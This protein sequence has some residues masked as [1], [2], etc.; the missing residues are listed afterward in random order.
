MFPAIA[1]QFG[2]VMLAG[3]VLEG[4]SQGRD[5]PWIWY[6]TAV[7]LAAIIWSGW[8]WPTTVI[9]NLL[10]CF[11]LGSVIW[12]ILDLERRQGY[13]W[14][15]L[16]LLAVALGMTMVR[17][18][19]SVVLLIL[20]IRQG[21][22]ILRLL[23]TRARWLDDAA[24]TFYRRPVLLFIG[25][26]LL[27]IVAGTVIL[28]F[29]LSSRL[30]EGVRLIDAL[31]TATSAV[32]VTGLVVLDTGQDF[33]GFGQT[34]ILLLFQVGGLGVLTVSTFATLLIT[35]HLSMR[36]EYALEQ[37][38]ETDRPAALFRLI[39][40]IVY[41][42]L[43]IE[44]A[45]ALL[46]YLT[47]DGWWSALFHSVSAFCNAGFSLNSDSLCGLQHN[48]AYLMTVTLLIVLGGLGFTV[49]E[50]I[51]ARLD[52]RRFD[53]HARLA[54]IGTLALILIGFSGMVLQ[55][56]NGGLAGLEPV[57]KV[58]NALFQSVTT[59]T[60]GFNSIPY[61][62]LQDS[63]V[64]L[65]LILMFIGACPGSTGGG[66]KVTTLLVLLLAVRAVIRGQPDVESGGRRIPPSIV[67]RA[68]VVVTLAVTMITVS[69]FLL[70]ATQVGPFREMAFEAVSAFA[71][72]GLS[73]GQTARLDDL[74][75]LVVIFLMF[76]GRVGPLSLILMF[77]ADKP[78]R[79]TLPQENILVG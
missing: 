19:G 78:R 54:L 18:G 12:S 31:F 69:L 25:G 26:F 79:W 40:F 6:S 39:R 29:H 35:G 73:L 71:T 55:E 49:I 8:L 3:S 45:G 16:V 21:W 72:V 5:T 37:M 76:A 51:R 17:K 65:M 15:D 77:A 48:L 1:L 61:D 23:A 60:A 53:L 66:I 32:C 2:C 44:A 70:F 74:G 30:P 7:V 27:L 56:W 58:A 34:V 13:N 43:G 20:A 57:E 22:I 68:M 42:T 64:F 47:A 36:E 11:L 75:K 59:R 52:G 33:S 28:T 41:S 24:K 38:V 10:L 14:L 4:N 9:Q 63:T 62:D 50:S 46:L 67:F